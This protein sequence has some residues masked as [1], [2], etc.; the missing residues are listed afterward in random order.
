[1][2]MVMVMVMMMVIIGLLHLK[3]G[4]GLLGFLYNFIYVL[5][6]H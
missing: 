1:M 5:K 4:K 2:M 6:N 3:K